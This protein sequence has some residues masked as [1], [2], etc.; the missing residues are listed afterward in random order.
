MPEDKPVILDPEI[1]TIENGNKAP[2]TVKPGERV[3]SWLANNAPRPVLSAIEAMRSKGKPDQANPKPEDPP[4]PPPQEIAEFIEPHPVETPDGEKTYN[5]IRMESNQEEAAERSTEEIK[6]NDMR[7]EMDE[8]SKRYGLTP[9]QDVQY[10]PYIEGVYIGDNPLRIAEVQ[11]GFMRYEAKKFQLPERASEIIQKFEEDKTVEGSPLLPRVAIQAD[12]DHIQ[13]HSIDF[14]LNEKNGTI[15]LNFKLTEATS[16]AL[17]QKM[18]PA[19]GDAQDP[20]YFVYK[21][22]MISESW[23]L[24]QEGMKIQIAKGELNGSRVNSA[25]GLVHITIPIHGNY[26]ETIRAKMGAIDTVLSKTIGVNDWIEEPE[27]DFKRE[28]MQHMYL[29]HNKLTTDALASSEHAEDIAKLRRQEVLP[30]FQTTVC[31]GKSEEY[32]QKYGDY[33]LYHFIQSADLLSQIMKSEALYSS[34]E[35]FKRG[36]N[37]KGWSTSMDFYFGGADGAFTRMVSEQGLKSTQNVIP[38][39]ASD[40]TLMVIVDPQELDRT[41]WYAYEEDKHGSRDPQDFTNRQSPDEMFQ[42]QAAAGIDFRNE[43]VFPVGAH[44]KG[45]GTSAAERDKV[46]ATLKEAG[47]LEFNGKPIEDSIFVADTYQDI[48]DISWDGRPGAKQ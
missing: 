46:I 45:I 11:L 35:R 15:A 38:L 48:M 17:L 4:E 8:L 1:P 44:I 30:G 21:D 3:L 43:Q 47:V 42:R 12:H 9:M 16:Q 20:N 27:E 33:G 23:D 39:R 28:E 6:L 37:I 40:A 29:E 26:Q 34:H 2:E 31:P 36:A 24:E 14:I 7:A 32:K 13:N 19:I 41:D 18:K 10:D 22:A 5:P 25:K